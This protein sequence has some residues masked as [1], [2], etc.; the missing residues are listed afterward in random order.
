VTVTH[1]I[2]VR[3]EIAD[4]TAAAYAGRIVEE[5]VSPAYPATAPSL[6][7]MVF[8]FCWRPPSMAA[9]AANALSAI[10]GALPNSSLPLV[11]RCAAGINAMT[12]AAANARRPWK[13]SSR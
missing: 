9:I 3:N 4:R 11:K 12:S 8:G 10:L 5:T 13:V 2:G 7:R 6:H 1:D